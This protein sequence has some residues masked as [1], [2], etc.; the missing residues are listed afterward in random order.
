[1]AN[2]SATSH[3]AGE[4]IHDG[5]IRATLEYASE[6]RED[7]VL[8]EEILDKAAQGKGL[9]HREAMVLLECTDTKIITEPID[10]DLFGM[11][12]AQLKG[13]SGYI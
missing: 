2:Y 10:T 7:M 1:M 13:M 6:H 12:A 4:F 9:S 3:L 11:S 5:E 8:I